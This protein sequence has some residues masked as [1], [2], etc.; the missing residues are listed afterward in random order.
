MDAPEIRYLMS[1]ELLEKYSPLTLAMD[2][3]RIIPFILQGQKDV[4]GTIGEALVNELLD[5]IY[6]TPQSLTPENKTLL[7]RIAPY[8][9]ARTVYYALPFLTFQF[10]QKGVTKESSEN[11]TAAGLDDIGFLRNDIQVQSERLREDLTEFLIEYPDIYPL[12]MEDDKDEPFVFNI[13]CP[14]KARNFNKCQRSW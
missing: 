13:F 6:S 11:S 14:K 5:Q 10:S 7:Q 12:Y 4:R 1:W 9:S 2:E 8:M 3:R